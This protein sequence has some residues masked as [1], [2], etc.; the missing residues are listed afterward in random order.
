M[1]HKKSVQDAIN[2]YM[3]N[4]EKQSMPTGRKNKKP[5]KIVVKALLE[6]LKANDFK[7]NVIEASSYDPISRAKVVCKVEAGFSDIIAT[8]KYGFAC[9]IE[10]KAKDRRATLKEHQRD[11]LISRIESNAFACCVDSAELLEVIYKGYIEL[12]SSGK[13]AK[14]FLLEQLP[15]KRTSHNDDSLF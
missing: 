3:Y 2:K 15:K 7:A 8:C 14:S 6:W 11:F 13:S 10:A 5:E 4:L 1:D 9:F 12:R